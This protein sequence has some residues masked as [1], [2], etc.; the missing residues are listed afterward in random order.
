MD[1]LRKIQPGGIFVTQFETLVSIEYAM[2]ILKDHMID[3]G[4]DYEPVIFMIDKDDAQMGALD[5]TW[6]SALKWLCGV[7]AMR[8]WNRSVPSKCRNQHE[9]D[10]KIELLKQMMYTRNETTMQQLEKKIL[11]GATVELK[12]YLQ[13]EWFSCKEKWCFAFRVSIFSNRIRNSN[14][15]ESWQQYVIYLFVN[16]NSYDT[17]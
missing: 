2:G 7:H 9:K 16:P 1:N 6:P 12:R 8:D 14:L 11:S 5:E 17:I 10:T 4:L 3:C 13:S 15:V